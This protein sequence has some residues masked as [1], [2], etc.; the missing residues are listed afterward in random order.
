M[1]PKSSD[2]LGCTIVPSVLPTNVI[3]SC[4]GPKLNEKMHCAYAD[5]SLSKVMKVKRIR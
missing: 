1:Y 4:S 5:L 3:G 2:P